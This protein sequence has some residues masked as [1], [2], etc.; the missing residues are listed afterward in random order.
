MGF[1]A[2]KD[3][4]WECLK[5]GR[6]FH[7]DIPPNYHSC[8]PI[9]STKELGQRIAT[10]ETEL[11]EAQSALAVERAQRENAEKLLREW[12]GSIENGRRILRE[13]AEHRL[14]KQA[15]AERDAWQREAQERMG[16]LGELI[17]VLAEI[18][19]P[20]DLKPN[21]KRIVE[22]VRVLRADNARLR[23]ALESVLPDAHGRHGGPLIQM[24]ASYE[25]GTS[26][27]DGYQQAGHKY[28]IGHHHYTK[29][30]SALAPAEGKP[31]VGCEHGA[32]ATCKLRPHDWCPK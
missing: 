5:C 23:G 29:A 30:R 15:E 10:L 17:V 8:E 13:E 4:G 27:R 32:C 28:A 6:I 1:I 20:K 9:L 2:T 11:A 25:D 3:G 16:E 21:A 26:H 31:G 22:N 24:V 7:G 19:D 18:L 12:D 14:R